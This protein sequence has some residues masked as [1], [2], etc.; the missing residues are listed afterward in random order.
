MKK[1][2]AISS[3]FLAVSF[4]TIA[5][6]SEPIHQASGCVTASFIVDKT[7]RAKDIKFPEH[8]PKDMFLEQAYQNITN[9]KH[10]YINDDRRTIHLQFS[11]DNSWPL[12]IECIKGNSKKEQQQEIDKQF[13]SD[14]KFTEIKKAIDT[15]FFLPIYQSISINQSKPIKKMNSDG[16]Y[17][18]SSTIRWEFNAKQ[19]DHIAKFYFKPKYASAPK[20]E[21]KAFSINR[22]AKTGQLLNHSDEILNYIGQRQLIITINLGKHSKRIYVGAPLNGDAFCAGDIASKTNFNTYCITYQNKKGQQI[23]FENIQETTANEEKVS[24]NFEIKNT[25]LRQ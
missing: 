15:K 25:F 13:L 18:I 24:T 14:A 9:I 19:A 6:I 22:N 12:P 1:L 7:G 4:N 2:I 5:K 20:V 23:T 10:R 21:M 8:H 11:T 17:N 3:I 16:T